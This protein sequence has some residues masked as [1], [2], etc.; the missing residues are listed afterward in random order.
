MKYIHFQQYNIKIAIII[1]ISILV[2]SSI[3]T[4]IYAVSIASK[5]YV[6]KVLMTKS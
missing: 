3:D 2:L 4:N 5:E 1:V 6:F